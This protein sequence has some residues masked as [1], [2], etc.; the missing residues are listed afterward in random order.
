[1]R[2]E[3]INNIA[4][5][6]PDALTFA[7]NPNICTVVS[8]GSGTVS[9]CIVK[10]ADMEMRIKTYGYTK[11]D[12]R[13]MLQIG[14]RNNLSPGYVNWDVYYTIDVYDETDTKLASLTAK[15]F[16]IWGA[17]QRGETYNIGRR[18][19]YF[20]GYPF[21]FQAYMNGHAGTIMVSNDGRPDG[22]V[23]IT[24]QEGIFTFKL[25]TS[26]SP[27]KDKYVIWDFD[28]TMTHLTFDDTFDLTFRYQFNGT[29]TKLIDVDV[30]DSNFEHPVY[31]RW[32]DRHGFTMYWLFKQG[33]EQRE[34]KA[35]T[36]YLRNNLVSEDA[37]SSQ[38][39]MNDRRRRYTRQDT[40]EICAPLVDRGQF[41]L[42][43]DLTT[44]PSVERWDKDTDT[45][46]AVTIK[47]GTYVK[48]A[49]EL[50]DFIVQVMMPEVALQSL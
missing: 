20:E 47:S 37:G 44:S 39:D 43:Q 27:A 36:E 19:A 17:L 42:L 1:M 15:S 16:V 45:W 40:I 3:V 50:Q 13:E 41:D 29:F 8:I 14:I 30:M 48:T 11:W 21:S 32:I 46:D 10:C 22:L 7:Y 25:P 35:D 18:M 12:M 33:D 2:N 6:Y 26:A 24:E 28:G 23:S 38:W 5:Q 49:E 9:Y 4:F 31:L 34:V